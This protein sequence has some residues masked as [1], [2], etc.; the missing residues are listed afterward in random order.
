MSDLQEQSTTEIVVSDKWVLLKELYDLIISQQVIPF[1]EK[2]WYGLNANSTWKSTYLDFCFDNVEFQIR[3]DVRIK[4]TSSSTKGIIGE[5]RYYLGHPECLRIARI[6]MWA[7]RI[8]AHIVSTIK[9]TEVIPVQ[10][11]PIIVAPTASSM[12]NSG[13]SGGRVGHGKS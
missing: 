10:T 7:E 6:T 4:I 12:G 3:R 1:T 11:N 2:V 13:M 9:P 5:E 8:N